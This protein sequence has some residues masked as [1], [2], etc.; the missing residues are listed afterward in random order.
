MNVAIVGYATEGK[1]S[2]QHWHS[3]GNTV[4]ICDQDDT[5][6]TPAEYQKQ[7]GPNYL[8]HLDRFDIIVRS[9]GIHPRMLLKDNRG[10]ESKITT[11]IEEFM[12]VC[13]TKNIIGVT[14]TKG[15]GTT[16]TLIS[17][18][19]SASGKTCHLG[20]NIG[21]PALQ[22]LSNIKPEDY[23]VLELSSFQLEDFK[24]PSPHIAVCIMVVPEHLNW[25][26]SMQEYLDA[27]S[28][29]F[30]YQQADDIA[31]Y[32]AGSSDSK[33][34]A[35][36]SKGQLI[37]YYQQPGAVIEDG[38]VQIDG[39]Q[40]CAV[41]SLKLI[42]KHNWQNIC[43]AVTAA[44][45]VTQDIESITSVLTTF[46]GLEHRIEFVRELEGISYYDDSF[47]TTPETSIAAIQAFDQPKIL[48]LGGSDKGIPLDPIADE[49]VKANVK[50]AIVVGDMASILES[51][52]RAR[53]FSNITSGPSTMAEMVTAAREQAT[54]GDVVLLS[55]GCAS[56]G[57]FK[58]YKDRGDQFKATVRALS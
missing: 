52:L 7:L 17:K 14:G 47:A 12:R 33:L 58:D 46:S 43:A 29:L 44:W 9:A 40:I 57:L 30:T 3:L 24:G 45:Q 31:I 34:I 22:L 41:D 38:Y 10:I 2:A 28:R 21:I 56:Y 4:T 32:Y 23:V 16:S 5:L 39:K 15:K 35:E 49:V 19:L 36:K 51:Q 42:G 27:K 54:A 53:G 48:I 11:N 20:G 1:V 18:I 8:S 13:P 25:H 37:P 50:H 55:T 6:V 26:A